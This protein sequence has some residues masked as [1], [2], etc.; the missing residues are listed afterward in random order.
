MNLLH[1]HYICR[2]N[3]L[4]F[5][6]T[7]FLKLDLEMYRTTQI[8]CWCLTR[9]RCRLHTCCSHWSILHCGLRRSARYKRDCSCSWCLN[10]FIFYFIMLYCINNFESLCYASIPC[11]ILHELN[12]AVDYDFS[13]DR[14]IHLVW[15][16]V[17]LNI[18]TCMSFLVHILS[19]FIWN[20]CVC[21]A[22]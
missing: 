5:V 2:A 21:D 13:C 19:H 10:H 1:I 8:I 11:F 20:M 9:S 17:L 7:N 15:F 16:C 12:I 22:T 6:V 4:S 14:V 18:Y 3:F